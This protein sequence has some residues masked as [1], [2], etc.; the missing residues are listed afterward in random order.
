M[1]AAE[2]LPPA[3]GDHEGAQGHGHLH[4]DQEQR[5]GV[6]HRQL[7]RSLHHLGL[8]VSTS[9]SAV[10]RHRVGR[11]HLTDVVLNVGVAMYVE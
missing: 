1:G 9:T 5:Q 2:R 10:S 8:S 7:R 6:C 11:L 3:A 4:Q